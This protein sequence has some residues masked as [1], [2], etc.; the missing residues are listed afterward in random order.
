MGITHV[1]RGDD[2]INNTPRQINILKALG[3]EQ[4]IYAHVPMV[5][6]SD[7]KRLS[8]RHGAVSVLA[9]RDAGYLPQALM[10]YLVRL[11]WSAGDQE[12]FSIE[13]MQSLFN[14]DH[15]S[16][17]P[18]A[19]D[20]DKLD[21]LNQHYLKTMDPVEVA[22]HFRPFLKDWDVA[23]GPAVEDVIVAQRERCKTLKEMA[24]RSLYFYSDDLVFDEKA[25]AKHLKP[26]SK[27]VLEPIIAGLKGLSDWT[28]ESIMDVMKSVGEDLGLKLGKVAAPMRVAVT[29][30]AVSPSLG[31]TLALIGRERSIA[32][33]ESSLLTIK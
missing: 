24:E 11:G 3:A 13:E 15:L 7:G 32:R 27:A 4:P 2:H 10:N 25:V 9:Y 29:G 19:F 8:K 20:F 26:E 17:S 6:G 12:I 16:H 22:P 28:S 14:I 23:N 30:G 21:W 33:L 31:E 1:I 5:L 18:A